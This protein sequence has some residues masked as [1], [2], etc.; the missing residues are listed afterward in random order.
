[1]KV[2]AA[3]LAPI[4]PTTEVVPVVEIPDFARITKLAADPRGTGACTVDVG[5]VV[6]MVVAI[7]VAVAVC[8]VADVDVVV[9]VEVVLQADISE[10]ASIMM[11]PIENH[12]IV[13]F[14]MK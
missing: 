14:I 5:V 9:D 12:D 6:A 13:L 10:T 4:S 7:V 11:I 1:M 2:A 8:V 3:G